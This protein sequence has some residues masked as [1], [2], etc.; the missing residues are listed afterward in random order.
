MANNSTF[1]NR[2]NTLRQARNLTVRELAQH[3]GVSGGLISGLIHNYRVIGELTAR[4]IGEALQ[5]SG[6]ELENFIYLAINNC[7][8]KILETS[9]PYPAEILNLVASELYFLGVMPDSICGC[10]RK[11]AFDD[12][13]ASLLLTDGRKATINLEVAFK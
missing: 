5:L 4:K 3:A 2:L 7:S 10:I 1:S 12:A 11:P 8:E 13:D 6:A 9:K